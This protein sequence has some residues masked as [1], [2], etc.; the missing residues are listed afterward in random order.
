MLK[1]ILLIM[2]FVLLVGCTTLK[3]GNFECRSVIINECD[4]LYE[5]YNAE[6]KEQVNGDYCLLVVHKVNESYYTVFDYYGDK[7]QCPNDVNYISDTSMYHG[8]IFID[9]TKPWTN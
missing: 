1:Q 5:K 4:Q 3:S 7:E 8:E 9:L 2:C 6:Q